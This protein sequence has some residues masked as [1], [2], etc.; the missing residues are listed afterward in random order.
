MLSKQAECVKNEMLE[1]VTWR[2][3]LTALEEEWCDLLAVLEDAVGETAASSF[4]IAQVVNAERMTL[5]RQL[6]EA[7]LRNWARI[8]KAPLTPLQHR[9]LGLR[10][11]QGCTWGDLVERV[12]KAKQ[13]L[14][15]E[16]NK[17]LEILAKTEDP[18]P[19]KQ[20]KK[21]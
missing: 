15:R 12:G 21:V 5:R 19:K 9:I 3:E 13:Y 7:Q 16:H 14:L 10:F 20:A 6:A 1:A 4:A 2:R 17:A 11:V 8:C 18:A